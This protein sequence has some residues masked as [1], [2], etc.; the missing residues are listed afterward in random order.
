MRGMFGHPVWKNNRWKT[1]RRFFGL[2]AACLLS[3]YG[4]ATMAQDIEPRAYS[5]A[6]VGVNFLITGYA[7]TDGGI[8]FDTSLPLTDPE[9]NTHNFVVAYARSLDLWGKS[10][11]VDIVWPYCWLSGSALYNG[12]PIERVVD[13]FAD[14]KFRLSVNLLGAPALSPKDFKGYKQDMIVG[15]SLQISAPTSQYDG[16]RLVN[17]GTNRWSFKPELG[18]SKAIGKWTLEATGAV[19]FFTANDDFYGGNR[20]SQDPLYSTQGHVIYSFGKGIWG[21]FD[22]TYFTGGRTTI[23]ETVK[24]DRQKNWRVGSTLA[25]PINVRSSIKFYLSNGVSARTGNNF[26]MAG[27]ALQYRWGGGL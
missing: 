13:G 1:L 27:V 3:C 9:L 24:E 20:R 5:N 12:A 15:L 26:L 23:G 14:S 8:A 17:I 6:P 16:S 4:L 18:I 21:S 19:T 2:L 22:V 7:F 25:V 11:K 10:G